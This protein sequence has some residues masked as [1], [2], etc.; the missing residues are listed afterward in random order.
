MDSLKKLLGDLLSHRQYADQIALA[1]EKFAFK[2]YVQR[3]YTLQKYLPLVRWLLALFSILTGFA[4]LFYHLGVAFHF[5]VSAL[6]SAGILVVL[7]LCKSQFW[8]EAFTELYTH[9][10]LSLLALL[11]LI[12]LGLSVF[13]SLHGAKQLYEVL[14][15]SL[16]L[17]QQTFQ[18]K[19]D[20]LAQHFDQRIQNE[21][22]ELAAFQESVSWQGKI[23]VE[24]STIQQVINLYTTQL[25]SLASQKQTALTDL[26][27]AHQQA[28]L[29]LQSDRQ[30][31]LWFWLSLSLAVELGVIACLWFRI[32]YQYRVQLEVYLVNQNPSYE[33]DAQT[34]EKFARNLLLH[35]QPL[36]P[37]TDPQAHH[38]IG[39]ARKEK[40]T[41]PPE[42]EKSTQPEAEQKPATRPELKPDLKLDVNKH[43]DFTYEEEQQRLQYIELQNYLEKYAKVVDCINQGM[44]YAKIIRACGVSKSTILNVKRCLRN[45]HSAQITMNERN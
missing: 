37:L 21:K 27:I 22:A 17:E 41:A 11:A 40:T 10:R 44:S 19:R 45:L 38:Q 26:K 32:Y 36:S 29:S 4:F 7:E 6:L 8:E 3:W 31:D 33:V 35:Q 15:Q 42:A 20:S 24:N 13:L 34:L 30:F 28:L 25:D 39:F 14:D 9:R 1:Q 12:T 23:N 5:L 16:T 43:R 2:P 18:Q